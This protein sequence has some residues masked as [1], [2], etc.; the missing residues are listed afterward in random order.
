MAISSS[1]LPTLLDSHWLIPAHPTSWMD[2]RKQTNIH[3]MRMAAC[4]RIRIAESHQLAMICTIIPVC[5]HLIVKYWVRLLHHIRVYCPFNCKN[6]PQ[7]AVRVAIR[8]R[9]STLLLDSF[10]QRRLDMLQTMLRVASWCRMATPI[11]DEQYTWLPEICFANRM[12]CIRV[13]VSNCARMQGC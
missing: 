6:I 13:P 3:I 4:K 5:S 9:L 2:H 8:Y 12:G 10:I 1:P 7:F 11:F